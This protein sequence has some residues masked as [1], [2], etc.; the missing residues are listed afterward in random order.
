ML[1]AARKRCRTAR[2]QRQRARDTIA[3]AAAS[4]G[5]DTSAGARPAASRP[6]G[7]NAGRTPGTPQA[8]ATAHAQRGGMRRAG[9]ATSR[10]IVFVRV[11]A[12]PTGSCEHR[13]TDLDYTEVKSVVVVGDSV[14]MLPSASLIQSQQNLQERMG[15]NAGLP[16]QSP[17]TGAAGGAT[18]RP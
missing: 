16:G 10:F 6:P 8:G 13:I 5:R 11:T 18:R 9:G 2:H 1:A 4:G 15:R 17:A 3:G 14:L 7:A 12:S